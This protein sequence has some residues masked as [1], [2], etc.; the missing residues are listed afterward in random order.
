MATPTRRL[1]ARISMIALAGLLLA[2]P[3]GA[4]G[5]SN[6]PI[7]QTGGMSATLPLMGTTLVVDVA[8]DE[9]GNIS[10]VTL[11]PSDTLSSTSTAKG[12]VKFS[13]ADGSVKVSVKASGDKMAIKAKASLANLLGAGTW[14][15]NVFGTGTATVDYV[16]GKDADGNPTVT[17]GDITTPSGVLATMLEPKS[18][19]STKEAEKS[20]DRAK[21]S[22]G[23]SFSHDGFTKR[24]MISISTKLPDGPAKL[25][26]VLSGRDRQD[27]SGTLAELAGARTWSA[28]L[29]DG[30]AVAV[31][32]HVT[33]D[34]TVVYDG[35]TG[36]PANVHVK[37][38]KTAEKSG[39]AVRFENTKVGVKVSLKKNDDGTYSLKV[40]GKSGRCPE[41]KKVKDPVG[42]G[43]GSDSE[44][45][46]GDGHRGNGHD[47]NGDRQGNGDRKKSGS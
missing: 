4:I 27:L 22:A 28:R 16:I 7:T 36:A 32:Y 46:K 47:D 24:L 45:R 12:V 2:F 19:A 8:L 3:S 18:K 31:N 9:V 44:I 1:A 20:E 38:T 21:A 35:A 33:A 30:T 13:N 25:S 5:N 15:A 17:I 43:K 23:V 10:G 37:K 6:N 34:G 11:N 40:T 26:I 42:A 41:D 14:S 29:C 39:F